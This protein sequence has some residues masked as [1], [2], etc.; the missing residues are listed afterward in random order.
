MLSEGDPGGTTDQA[1][2][3][4]VTVARRAWGLVVAV[5]VSVEVGVAAVAADA[6]D[7]SGSK[8][9]GVGNEID[10]NTSKSIQ[11]SH[12]CRADG[13]PVVAIID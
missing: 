9:M 2:A 6:A 1:L 10:L 5:E 8:I 3:P 4:A 7:K 13:L 12:N 11:S